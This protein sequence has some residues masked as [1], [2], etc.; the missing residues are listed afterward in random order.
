MK[1]PLNR[2]MD[3]PRVAYMMSRFPKLTE[4]F[5]L[6]EMLQMENLGVD[7]RVYPLWREKASTVH[8]ETAA[9]TQRANFLPTLNFEILRDSLY[10][11]FTSPARYLATFFTVCWANRSSLR[12]LT[13]SLAIFPKCATFARRM[14]AENI[15]HIHAHF[16][17]HPAAAAFIVNKLTNIPWSFTAHGSDLHRCQAMLE[18]KVLSAAFTVTVS[19]YNKKF[20]LEHT[21][22]ASAD[23]VHVIHCGVD[24][25]RFCRNKPLD[26]QPNTINIVCT[27]TLHEVK[28]Q[29]YL[30][31]ACASLKAR[32][33]H[34]H[35]IGDGPDRQK[36]QAL[37]DDLKISNQVTFH[38]NCERGRVL[39]LLQ[40][41]HICCVP[42]VPTQNGRREGIPVAM[43]EAAAFS[44]PIVASNLSGIP[45]FVIH[46][47]TGL[48]CEPKDAQGICS[49]LAHLLSHDDERE[50]LGQQARE[51]LVHEFSL[52]NTANSLYKLI[53]A[54]PASC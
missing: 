33:W 5:V 2:S 11:L 51:K 38:G 22:R 48:L 24:P 8:A 23:R 3:S 14:R 9:Y 53:K 49:A 15:D 50:R 10:W 25:Q 1:L 47:E 36:L 32:N 20:I 37:A 54:E 19:S 26:T 41:M 31:Q 27:G 4:T 43:M 6:D 21:S 16:A 13:G 42:S 29:R 12:F 7:V 46:H 40:E 39:A 18:E 17:S 45:E 34:C 28:G 30:L 52:A 35:L 44:I